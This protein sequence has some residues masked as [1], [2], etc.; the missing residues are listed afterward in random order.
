LAKNYA[1]NIRA[2][3]VSGIVQASPPISPV[4]THG[5][6]E[7]DR[8]LEILLRGAQYYPGAAAYQVVGNSMSGLIEHGEIV[9]VNPNDEFNYVRP[10]IFETSNGYIVKLR[11][12]H[13]GRPALLSF[14]K[15]VAPITNMTDFRARGS[16]YGVYLK[17][18]T[19]R[20]IS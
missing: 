15:S 11:G 7:V 14:N 4:D 16:V 20:G 9:L 3:T 17:A 19:I 10:C 8:A 12:L 18:F 5:D 1:P 13:K 2:L 6:F